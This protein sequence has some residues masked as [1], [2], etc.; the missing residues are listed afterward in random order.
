[1]YSDFRFQPYLNLI[2]IE[3]FRVALSR[4]RFS[5]HRLEVETGRWHKPVAVPFNERKCRTC[6]NCLED[7]IHFLLEC[8]LY[9]ELRK[10]YIKPYYW[11]RLNMPKF[12]KLIKT[13]NKIEIRNV[14]MFVMKSFEIRK[15]LYFD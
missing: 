12:I 14:S 10:T 1:M 6:L 9:H 11:K 4:F 8:P 5:A 2:N 3:H 15:P 13:E 7:E